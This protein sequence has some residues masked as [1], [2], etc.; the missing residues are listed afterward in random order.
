MSTRQPANV[1]T[2]AT[3][4]VGLVVQVSVAPPWVRARVTPVTLVVTVLPP[5][6]WATTAGWVER[7]VADVPLAGWMV[8]ASLLALPTV[9]VKLALVV[10]V[11]EPPAA[12]SV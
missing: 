7:A 5:A 4:G 6:S 11:S 12:V 8:N 10:D 1:A 3:A 9:T 2:P